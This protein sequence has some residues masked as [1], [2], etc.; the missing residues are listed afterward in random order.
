[1]GSHNLPS[2]G[3][4][5]PTFGQ[6]N[7]KTCSH[8]LPLITLFYLAKFVHILSYSEN[9]ECHNL[10][11]KVSYLY[12]TKYVY[13]HCLNFLPQILHERVLNALSC[14][15]LSPIFV[16]ISCSRCIITLFVQHSAASISIYFTSFLILDI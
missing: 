5:C 9:R 15:F 1:M 16:Q 14:I 8:N 10:H 13:W 7:V 6:E 3:V 11:T 4:E 2:Y 12:G